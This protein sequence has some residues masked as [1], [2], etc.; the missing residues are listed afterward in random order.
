MPDGWDGKN[1]LA[2]YEAA[3]IELETNPFFSTIENGPLEPIDD[4]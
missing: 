3:G 2:R 1:I 4:A